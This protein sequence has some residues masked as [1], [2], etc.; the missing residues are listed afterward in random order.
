[1]HN[2]CSYIEHVH[3]LFFAH[4]INIFLVLGLLNLD[5][6]PSKMPGLCN[7]LLQQFSILYIQS[8]L[9]DCSHI[10]PVHPIFCAHLIIYLGVLNLD[11]IMSIP[12]SECLHCV[13]CV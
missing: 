13:I 4:L 2:Y 11:I 12:P 5:I 6:F 10:E 8:L 9:Y 7:L 3:L 1:M